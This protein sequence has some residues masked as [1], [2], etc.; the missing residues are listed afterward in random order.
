MHKSARNRVCISSPRR[1]PAGSQTYAHV[2]A[3]ACATN[4]RIAVG[5]A[6]QQTDPFMIVI[7]ECESSGML[8][9]GPA[10]VYSKVFS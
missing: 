3:V 9:Y 10:C 6:V 8:L 5:C 1:A 2:F 4:W 7:L